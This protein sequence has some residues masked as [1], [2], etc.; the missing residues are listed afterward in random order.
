MMA[1][2]EGKIAMSEMRPKEI[3]K[4]GLSE[5]F[6][7]TIEG[8]EDLPNGW[9]KRLASL[10]A[11]NVK[12]KNLYRYE[13]ERYGM[14]PVRFLS[15]KNDEAHN[16]GKEPL[17]DGAVK[18]YRSVGREGRLAFVGSQTVKYIPKGSEVDLQLGP[19]DLVRVKPV[20]MDYSTDNYEW[21]N[22]Q[23]TGWDEHHTVKVEVENSQPIPV[24]IELRRNIPGR[25]WELT[26]EGDA[27]TFEK[28]DADTV[29]YT[30]EL[31]AGEKKTFS[32][33][34]LLKQG[35]RAM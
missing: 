32:Y 4:E 18:V 13:E 34:L 21:R 15:F 9:G 33:K 1:K 23:V 7:Y 28:V 8:T 29:Q 22:D 19:T 35:S 17:P 14:R 3:V 2:A 30:L 5:Y 16:L 27:G 26:S 11:E 31:K 12:V 20:L 25:K 6:L 10:T 24:K